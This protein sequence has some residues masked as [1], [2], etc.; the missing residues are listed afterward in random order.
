MRVPLGGDGDI[1]DSKSST[2]YGCL[3]FFF[4]PNT[5]GSTVTGDI[6]VCYALLYATEHI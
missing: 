1:S 2:H 6:G 3:P 4:P 5:D